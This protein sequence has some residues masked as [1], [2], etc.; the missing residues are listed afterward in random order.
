MIEF[1]IAEFPPEWREMDDETFWERVVPLL[2]I[3]VSNGMT[4]P[5]PSHAEWVPIDW[6][7]YDNMVVV[8]ADLTTTK[9]D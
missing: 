6:F 1:L 9:G 3:Y 5:I 2:Q 4:R 8:V 7:T